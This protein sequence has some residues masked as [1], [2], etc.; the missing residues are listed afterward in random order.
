MPSGV[1]VSLQMQC[2][3]D[4]SGGVLPEDAHDVHFSSAWLQ[5]GG[6]DSPRV[7]CT[8]RIPQLRRRAGRERRRKRRTNTRRSGHKT[9]PR[10][11]KLKHS[12]AGKRVRGRPHIRQ[13]LP[14]TYLRLW[15]CGR[16]HFGGPCPHL[17]CILGR[18]VPGG[19]LARGGRGQVP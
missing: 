12:I 7:P 10:A 19:E 17:L 3:P 5:A 14:M 18:L 11:G 6:H 15:I 13:N 2:L 8:L 1:V 9:E 4:V 16:A